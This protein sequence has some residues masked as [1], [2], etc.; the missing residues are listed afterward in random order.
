MTVKQTDA[1][2]VQVYIQ[3]SFQKEERFSRMADK[4]SG[5]NFER[6]EVDADRKDRIEKDKP[7]YICDKHFEKDDIDTCKAFNC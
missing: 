1:T 3:D 2:K 4:V 6:R 7:T 5:E